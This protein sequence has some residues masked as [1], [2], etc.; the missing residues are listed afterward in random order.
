MPVIF[1]DEPRFLYSYGYIPKSANAD[2]IACGNMNNRSTAYHF[3]PD[4]TLDG[5]RP[6]VLEVPFFENGVNSA[7]RWIPEEPGA[8]V[9]TKNG[10]VGIMICYESMFPTH[11]SKLVSGGTDMFAVVTNDSWFD[12]PL[13]QNLHIANG[14][15]RAVETGRPLVQSSINGITAAIDIRGNVIA[16]LKSSEPGVLYADVAMTSRDTPYLLWGDK[17]LYLALFAVL[18]SV[19]FKKRRTHK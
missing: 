4:G 13:A 17:W 12:T 10:K 8:P 6:K 3:T 11:A 9:V 15:Y 7:F 19:L 1:A 2:M 16:E 14:I 18:I 5:I